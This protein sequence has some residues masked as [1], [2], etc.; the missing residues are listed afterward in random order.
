MAELQAEV[1]RL[2]V[3]L[4]KPRGTI[5]FKTS[6]NGGMILYGMQRFPVTLKAEQWE[7]LV[8]M[9]KDGTITQAVA[10]HRAGKLPI[11]QVEVREQ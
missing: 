1:A 7:R 5:T 9:A 8:Q 4:E 6:S 10:D 11:K 2:K 3:A